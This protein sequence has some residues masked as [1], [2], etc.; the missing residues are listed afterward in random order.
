MMNKFK[1]LVAALCLA[2]T[3]L[4]SAAQDR[5]TGETPADYAE[6]MAWFGDAK[7]GIFIHW[8]IYAVKGVSESWSFYNGRI[9]FD[10]YMAQKKGFTAANYNAKEWVDL[11]EQSGAKYTVLT[12]KHHDGFCLWDTK[13]TKSNAVK[14]SPAKRDLIAPFAEEVKKRKDLH[15]G[16][17]FSL[18][19]WSRDDYPNQTRTFSRYDIK[20]EPKRW[21]L[22]N[23]NE[24]MNTVVTGWKPFSNPRMFVGYGRQRGWER[25]VSGNELSA[26]FQCAVRVVLQ[27]GAVRYSAAEITVI[28]QAAVRVV[29][30]ATTLGNAV[31]KI[32]GEQQDSVLSDSPAALQRSIAELTGQGNSVLGQLTGAVVFPVRKQTAVQ[33][34]PVLKIK[35]SAAAVFAAGIL[36]GVLAPAV[37]PALLAVFHRFSVVQPAIKFKVGKFIIVIHPHTPGIR[38]QVGVVHLEILHPP[39]AGEQRTEYQQIDQ[40]QRRD[41]G[42]SDQHKGFCDVDSSPVKVILALLWPTLRQLRKFPHGAGDG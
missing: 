9:S 10:D 7:L 14:Q 39:P 30:L 6:R 34:C 26:V 22:H 21:Q 1:T 19:D 20:K 17:Y 2:G 3:A 35:Y 18:L 28:V 36:S 16:L 33:H 31:C 15:L 42:S 37:L 11:I 4:S 25:D 13:T 40:H 27:N 41:H 38:R 5:V 8:G 32:P 29:L 12:T 23:I 24:I